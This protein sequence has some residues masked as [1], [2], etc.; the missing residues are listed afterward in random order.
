MTNVT[1]DY[2]Y[3]ESW[4]LLETRAG[5][6]ANPV[7]QYLWHPY[8]IDALAVRWYDADTD[9]SGIADYYYQQDANFNVTA[10]ADSA[11]R[12][13]NATSTRP[14]ASDLPQRQLQQHPAPPSATP[15]STPDASSMR[16]RGCSSIEIG[17][18][19]A[20]SEGG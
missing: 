16:R 15:T 7:D 3:N 2:Y 17:S 10:V 8:Y 9:G 13:R 18:I 11:A 14:T 19:R 5:S 4:Q 6:S 12:C 20:C 1:Y